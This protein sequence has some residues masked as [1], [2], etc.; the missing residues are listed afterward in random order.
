MCEMGGPVRQIRDSGVPG[1]REYRNLYGGARSPG[2]YLA[3][4]K[5]LKP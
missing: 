5:D 2:S 4:L 3:I 1:L